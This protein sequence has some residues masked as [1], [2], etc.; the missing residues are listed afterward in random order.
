MGGYSVY[1]LQNVSQNS[2][3]KPDVVITKDDEGWPI[4]YGNWLDGKP[5]TDSPH[6]KSGVFALTTP[7]R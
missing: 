2:S 1:K 4:A 7:K 3:E 6:W 5:P